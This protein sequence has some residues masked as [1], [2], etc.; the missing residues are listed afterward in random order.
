MISKEDQ[1][2]VFVMGTSFDSFE[3]CLHHVA[4]LLLLLD[5]VWSSG[6]THVSDVID[7]EV[8]EDH[9]VPVALLHLFRDVAGDVAVDFGVV[10]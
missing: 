6:S 4:H 5:R 1:Q 2:S 9:R 3:D 8:M 10:L 7:S